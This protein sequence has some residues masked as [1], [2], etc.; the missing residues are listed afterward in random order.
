M[1]PNP[2]TGTGRIACGHGHDGE[3]PRIRGRRR[4]RRPDDDARRRTVR[5]AGGL[6][7]GP[8]AARCTRTLLDR[9]LHLPR[10]PRG[11]RGAGLRRGAGD[12][13]EARRGR[14]LPVQGDRRAYRRPADAAHERA[15]R[16]DRE[17][18]ARL[19]HRRVARPETGVHVARVLTTVEAVRAR[20]TALQRPL[21][22][23]DG[24]GGTQVPD[25][26][27]DAVATYFRESNAN[28][29]GPYETSR[30][31]EALVTQARVT[32]ADFLGCTPDETIFG[33]NMTTLNFALSRTVGR[34]WRAGDEIVVTK[35]D[36]DGN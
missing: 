31:T 18:G 8:P 36:H 35:L 28:V 2:R 25:S 17:G 29:S 26:V 34:T 12:R 10:P 24:P 30:R 19:L 7:R 4:S 33:A 13:H 15:R 20:F 32:A 22:F 23:F 27:I 3:G 9:Q 11:P 14:P 6:V 21:A 5:P 1:V 16:S